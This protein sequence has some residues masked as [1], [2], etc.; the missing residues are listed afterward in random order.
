[1]K[2]KQTEQHFEIKVAGKTI[3]V[4]PINGET[5]ERMPAPCVSWSHGLTHWYNVYTDTIGWCGVTWFEK[6]AKPIDID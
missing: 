1:M 6:N 2:Y 4:K 5:S 3:L